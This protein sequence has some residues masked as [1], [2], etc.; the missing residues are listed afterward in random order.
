MQTTELI[1]AIDDEISRLQ[2][3]RNLLAGIETR[4]GAEALN[5]R[6][7]KRTMS[8]EARAKIAAAQKKRWA[9]HKKATNR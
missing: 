1:A 9:V 2:A 4:N 6:G 3:A 7:G 5:H 8:A